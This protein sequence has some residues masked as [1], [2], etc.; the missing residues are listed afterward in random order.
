MCVHARQQQQQQQGEKCMKKQIQQFSCLTEVSEILIRHAIER[1]KERERGFI[2]SY[3][4]RFK[5]MF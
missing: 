1:E 3:E 2:C 4:M 5:E